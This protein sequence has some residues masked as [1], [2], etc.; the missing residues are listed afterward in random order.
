EGSIEGSTEG[1]VEG[2][3][4]G[5]WEILPI[6][7]A[8]QDSDGKI[9]LGELLRI[10]QFFNAGGFHCEEGT[11][12]GYAPYFD[13]DKTCR[14]HASDYNPRDWKISLPELLRLIQFFNTG[15]YHRCDE[16]TE[17]GYCPGPA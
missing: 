17:D 11:E 16:G 5:E 7:S 9:S 6:H 1:S 3:T 12:D 4:E 2:A 13:G 8:D 10:I 14:P 15:S